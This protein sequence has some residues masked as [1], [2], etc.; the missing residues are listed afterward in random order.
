MVYVCV[1]VFMCACAESHICFTCRLCSLDCNNR[2]FWMTSSASF[3]TAADLDLV[4]SPGKFRETRALSVHSTSQLFVNGTSGDRVE[5]QAALLRSIAH[6][7]RI[8]SY[9]SAI[10]TLFF[11]HFYFVYRQPP[12]APWPAFEQ[13]ARKDVQTIV[14]HFFFFFM[15]VFYN[16][17]MLAYFIVWIT[18]YVEC[19][20]LI[21]NYTSFNICVHKLL[22]RTSKLER[23]V[24]GF[25]T[26]NRFVVKWNFILRET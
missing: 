5:I 14:H 2:W 22:Q 15:N 24:T 9:S 10:S 8:P 20:S 4:T 11:I 16:A 19:A 13:S 3:L 21:Y 25:V 12:I 7:I 1:C 6:W 18:Q 23:M 17:T 26:F